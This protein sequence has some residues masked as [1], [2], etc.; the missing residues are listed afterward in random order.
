MA[1]PSDPTRPDD[2]TP[3]PTG[4]TSPDPTN[5]A[6]APNQASWVD[7][8]DAAA[9]PTGVWDQTGVGTAPTAITSGVT[10]YQWVLTAGQRVEVQSL[11]SATRLDGEQSNTHLVARISATSTQ[12]VLLGFTNDQ[13]DT[14]GTLPTDG[15][16]VQ[17]D[18]SGN[19][20]L[21]I[22]SASVVT[23]VALLFALPPVGWFEL[24]IDV[25]TFGAG[26][27]QAHAFLAGIPVAR[28]QD[29]AAPTGWLWPRAGAKGTGTLALDR[30][31]RSTVGPTSGENLL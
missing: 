24:S 3:D 18:S 2:F 22:A 25:A 1:E 4:G 26:M 27:I 30:M 12:E 23:D 17:R 6:A 5:T 21:R 19:C 29:V 13:T 9:W 20:L 28:A 16:W 15:V 7:E 31:G 14:I 8:M 10:A 11:L